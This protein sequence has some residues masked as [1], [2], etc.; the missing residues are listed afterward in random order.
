M[1]DYLNRYSFFVV[2]Y[3]IGITGE[4]IC[5]Y[6]ALPH[7]QATQALSITLPNTWNITFNFCYL[8]AIIMFTYIPG[9][10]K[11]IDRSWKDF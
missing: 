2:L 1:Y 8:I 9:N 4:L 10:F 6:K 5:C 3:P 7:Y 11:H